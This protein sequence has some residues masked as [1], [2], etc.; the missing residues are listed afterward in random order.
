MEVKN[1]GKK[2]KRVKG[3]EMVGKRTTGNNNVD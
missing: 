1:G 3:N 2:R